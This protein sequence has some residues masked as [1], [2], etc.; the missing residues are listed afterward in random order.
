[1]AEAWYAIL[2]L[3]AVLFVLLDGWNIG[4][5]VVSFRVARTEAERRQIVAALGPLWSWHEVWLLAT[6]G[7]LF[8]AFPDVLATAL[9][10]FYLAFFLLLW[11]F[12]LRGVALEFGGHLPDPLWRSFFDTVFALSSTLL[13]ILLGAA[14]GNV[15]RGVPLG[16]DGRFLA[17][18]FTDWSARGAVGILDWYTVLVAIFTFAV[19]AAHGAAYLRLRTEGPLHD[20]S[21]SAARFLWIVSLA[22]LPVVTVATTA[23]R[24]EFFQ[25]MAGRPLAWAGI[26]SV[27]LGALAIAT[28]HRSRREGRSFAGGV[29]VITGLLLGAAA[30]AYPVLLRSTLAPEHSLSATNALAPG[31]GPG[32]ALVWWPVAFLLSLGYAGFVHRSFRSRARAATIATE[33]PYD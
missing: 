21:D 7:V 11:S 33:N 19:L 18:L 2:A 12:L 28:G 3:T 22:L 32:F 1:M 26:L 13:A 31:A 16:P 27:V 20:R 25:H 29:L 4:A 14:F 15:L 6:G 23:V 9:S 8:L 30:S 5:G 17:P 24:P 10:G